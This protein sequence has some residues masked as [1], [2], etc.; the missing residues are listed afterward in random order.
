[1]STATARHDIHRPSA[2]NPVEYAYIG[3]F[4]Q[5]ASE[6]VDYA[7]RAEHAH[8]NEVFGGRDFLSVTVPGGNYATK[9]TCDHCGATFSYGSFYRH[10]PTG[11]IIAVG[12]ICAANTMLPGV[13][14]AARHRK[15]VERAV[16]AA[17]TARINAAYRAE[18]LAEHPGLEEALNAEHYIVQDIASRFHGPRPELSGKQV[19]LVFKI[20]REVAERE[21]AEAARLANAEPV[22]T[23]KGVQIEGEVVGLKLH[24]NEWG[25]TWKM[26]VA[27]DR[28]F[29]VWGTVPSAISPER[30]DR[31]RFVANV[32]A[33]EDD[34]FFGFFKRPRKAEVVEIPEEEA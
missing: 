21:A 13:D 6:D 11:E 14:Q 33:A 32:E 29:K 22:V 1:M 16:E 34:E 23:G 25:V 12:H 19:A 15:A 2:I 5:G 20:A 7:Y 27:D 31:V 10:E 17:K 28:G 30:G 24:E 3:E 4:Y 18:L 26:V 8:L 9:A